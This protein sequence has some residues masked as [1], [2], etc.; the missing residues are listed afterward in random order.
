MN[1]KIA[2]LFPGQ[3]AQ[4]LKMGQDVFES[5][6]IAREVFEE[7]EEILNYPISELIFNGTLEKLTQTKYSQP[8]IFITSAALLK[9]FTERY[10][11]IQPHVCSGLS[12]GEYTALFASG[13]LSFSETLSLVQ[14]RANFMQE[15][16]EKYPGSLSVILGLEEQE[17]KALIAPLENKVW[18]A[19]LNCPKQVVIS[20]GFEGLKEAEAL[21][22]LGGAKRV[23]PL[24]VSGAFHSG[25]MH[26]AQVKLKEK[27]EKVQ[28]LDSQTHLVMNVVGDF[29]SSKEEIKQYLIEQVAN[30]TRWEKGIHSIER[31]GIDAYIEIGPGKTLSGMNKRI[32]VLQPTLSV[33]NYKEIENFEA[34]FLQ[35]T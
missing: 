34:L 10:P 15:A 14:Q 33:E 17:V 16:S 21:V 20:G 11:E 18:V 25:L 22:K 35:P 8:A 5:S 26:E 30:T 7:A 2:F 27:I 31:E 13:K 3:G 1:K 9:A 19:N 29:V 32:Q 6:Q 23:L 4:Y 24:E 28:F 12:L